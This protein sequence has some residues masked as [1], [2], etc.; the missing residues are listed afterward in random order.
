MCG[1]FHVFIIRIFTN[2][3]VKASPVMECNH[4]I[5]DV[6]MKEIGVPLSCKINSEVSAHMYIYLIVI[7]SFKRTLT[8]FC[9]K[10][11]FLFL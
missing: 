10:N 11:D 1:V 4:L 3:I 2:E 8:G 6:L 7:Q 5:Q 9:G